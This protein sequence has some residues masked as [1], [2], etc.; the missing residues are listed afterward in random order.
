MDRYRMF[1][2]GTMFLGKDLA[3]NQFKFY[4]AIICIIAKQQGAKSFL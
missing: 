4:I 2:T 3:F 1:E